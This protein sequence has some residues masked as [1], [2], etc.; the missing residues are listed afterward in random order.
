MKLLGNTTVELAAGDPMQMGV[1]PVGKHMNFAVAVPGAEEVILHLCREGETAPT[2]SVV[3]EASERSGA[4][5]SVLLKNFSGRGM[6]YRYETKGCPFVDPCARLLLGREI[7]GKALSRKER[8]ALCAPVRPNAFDWKEDRH[9]EIPLSEL[10][11]YKLHVRGF[12]MR[13]GVA[14]KGTFRGVTERIPY[15]KQLGI[16]GVLLMPCMEFNEI[17][18]RGAEEGIPSFATSKFYKSSALEQNDFTADPAA[19]HQKKQVNFWGYASHYFFFAPKASY[20]AQPAHADTECK[21]MVR[22]LH[23]EGMEV[24]ME[25]NV[26]AGTNRGLV[27]SALR[28][29]VREYHVDGFRLN[30]EEL[31]ARLLAA[32]PYLARTKLL[33]SGWDACGDGTQ[34]RHLAVYHDGF[35]M[36]CRRFLKSDE[37]MAGAFA[38]RVTENREDC[39]TVNYITDHNGFTLA[40]LYQ[41]DVKHNEANGENGRDGTDY[42]CSWNCGAEGPDKRKK[43][44]ELRLKM[45]KNALMTLLLSQGTPMLL[46]GDEIGNSQGGNN[47]AYCQ[48]NAVGWVD[49]RAQRSNG[50]LHGFVRELIAF[51]KAHPVLHN[52]HGLHGTD[53]LQ[54]GCPDVS[55]HSTKIWYPD[56]SRYNRCVAILLSGAFA[57]D[58]KGKADA[59]MYLIFNMYWEEREFDIP[60][61]PGYGEWKL[62]LASDKSCPAPG[63]GEATLRVPPRTV[64]VL[65]CEPQEQKRPAGKRK[66]AGAKPEG[67]EKA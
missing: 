48:D 25:V 23:Q 12:T 6:T 56:E 42:N 11:L 10:L 43:I 2:F 37:G 66:S 15:L 61:L 57:R 13:S 44:R 18:E 26:P 16:N 58:S 36:D 47:N 51:R 63:K 55:C 17:I 24:L 64:A 7:Y 50:E 21:E 45:K 28:F 33:G 59:S 62:A 34:E 53:Y 9:P 8:R 54:S 65:V 3:M 60:F 27:L 29:W 35:L 41:Y 14:H 49:W 40:D 52:A 39:G 1:H 30:L 38:R 22:R 4:V 19:S 46:A 67:E 20:A 32:D 31:D 5:F